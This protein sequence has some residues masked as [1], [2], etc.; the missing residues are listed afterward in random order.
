MRPLARGCRILHVPEDHVV[1]RRRGCVL[2]PLPPLFSDPL[3]FGLHE[4]TIEQELKTLHNRHLFAT[5]EPNVKGK[6]WSWFVTKMREQSRLIGKVPRA[7]V[8][9]VISN[10]SSMKRLRFGSGMAR[11]CRYGVRVQD[12][13]LTEMQKLEFYDVEKLGGKEDRGIQF[14]SPTYNA[15]LA[16]HLHHIEKRFYARARNPD[17][18]P[19]VAKGRSPLER[20]L[21][22]AA[23]CKR[24]SNPRFYLLDHSRFDAHVNPQ[25][26]EQEH[27]AYLR[28]RGYNG[29]L[30]WLLSQQMGT[31]G[32]S[33]GGIVY[34]TNGKRSSGDLNTGLGNT[35]LNLA[36]LEAY[37]ESQ[38]E[39]IGWFECSI[40]LDGDDSVIIVEDSV[41]LKGIERFMLELGMVTEVEVAD[42]L[43]KA[44]FCQSR[45]CWG[46]LGPVMVRNPRKV[47]DVLTKSPRWLDDKQRRGVLAASALGE[48][49]QAPGVPVLSVAASS[50]LT[51][52]CSLPRF[53]TPDAY[54]RF[55]IYR[56]KQIVVEVDETMRE[57]FAFAWDIEPQMQQAIEAYYQDMAD[58]CTE[59]PEIIPPKAKCKAEDFETW[60]DVLLSDV[61]RRAEDAWWLRDYPIG[62]LV[63][64]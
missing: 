5:P 38:R 4:H 45:I 19:K 48:L 16:R 55:M 25:L 37:I 33:H 47:L 63:G 64:C 28:E 41:E 6:A 12:A 14:R 52:A 35:R 9:E 49:M 29:E 31:M 58:A 57:S 40:F 32:F 39:E 30:N 2:G 10:R 36:M 43:E 53:T 26:L 18:T 24:F 13:Y 44:E 59:M 51:M 1:T 15:A 20:G 11:Y 21:I 23:M 56:T 34:K 27:R 61:D 60:D 17:G 50:L 46:S 3:E 62:L 7:S 22:L 42:C 54:E 8:R